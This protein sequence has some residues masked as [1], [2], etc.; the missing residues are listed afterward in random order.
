MEGSPEGLGVLVRV[1]GGFRVSEMDVCVGLRSPENGRRR[2]P[3]DRKSQTAVE[4][5]SGRSGKGWPSVFEGNG[6]EQERGRGV[7]DPPP[8]RWVTGCRFG[9]RTGVT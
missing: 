4:E 1:G 6:L 9:P 3:D 7:P 2:H 5:C 8:E